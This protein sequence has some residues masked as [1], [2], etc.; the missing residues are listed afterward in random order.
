MGSSCGDLAQ[1]LLRKKPEWTMSKGRPSGCGKP[2]FVL[3]KWRIMGDFFQG[4]VPIY[5]MP[6]SA[7]Q[8]EGS[9]AI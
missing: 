1:W 5:Y 7:G 6:V 2:R 4:A 3:L 8:K 9:Q